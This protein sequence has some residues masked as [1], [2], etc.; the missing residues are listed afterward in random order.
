[1]ARNRK[2]TVVIQSFK[3][4]LRL[5]WSYQGKQLFLYCGLADTPLN[6]IVAE[7]KAKIIE[8]DLATGNFDPTLGKYKPER[9]NQISVVNLFEKFMERRSRQISETSLAKYKGLL[10]KLENHFGSKSAIAIG[11]KEA[12]KFIHYLSTEI[13]PIT[14]RERLSLLRSCWNF[15]IKKKLI[16]ENPWD[17]IKIKV[18]PKRKPLPFTKEEITKISHCFIQDYPHYSDF[19]HFLFGVGCRTGEA[20]GLQWK[21]INDDCSQVWIGESLSRGVRKDTKNSKSRTINLTP[22]LQ[23]ILLSRRP[24]DFNPEDLIFTAPEGGAIDDHNFR[25]R[26]WKPVLSKL[27]IPYRKP[28]TTRHTLISH[29]LEQGMNPV[30]VADL[31]GHNVKTLY[32]HYAG[33]INKVILPD[34]FHSP[35]SP[36]SSQSHQSHQS[37]HSPQFPQFPQSPPN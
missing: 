21:H 11:E 20:I 25:N 33:V 5:V 3:G 7:G 6:R 10:G 8:G 35:Q 18:P 24:I 12:E 1:M 23:Q 16:P 2:G 22:Y 15:G 13:A 19:L 31:T 36:H 26:A 4:V 37:P 30:N 34:I 28:Y 9:Q 32:D 14:V 27:G 29:A 17:D